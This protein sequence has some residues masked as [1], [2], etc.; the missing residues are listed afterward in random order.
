[1]KLPSGATTFV[2]LHVGHLSLAF[3]RSEMVMVSSKGFWHVSHRNS[4]LGMVSPL[5]SLL[6]SVVETRQIFARDLLD[7]LI[8]TRQHRGR[9]CQAQGFRGLQIDDEVKLG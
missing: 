8:R 1:M 3:S 6:V 9:D 4:Y 5:D 2:P 7:D